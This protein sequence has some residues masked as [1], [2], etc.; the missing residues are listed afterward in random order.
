MTELGEI[1]PWMIGSAIVSALVV[2]GAVV[3]S[4]WVRKSE[5]TGALYGLSSSWTFS[6]SWASNVTVASTALLAVLASTDVV[7]VALGDD[8]AESALA[9]VLVAS[10][11]SAGLVG[12]APLVLKALVTAD[13][14][15]H[16]AGLSIAALLTLTGVGIEIGVASANADR[17]FG[18]DTPYIVI[19][20]LV[21][22]AVAATYGFRSL[23]DLLKRTETVP[24]PP[25]ETLQA[26]GLIAEAILA[27]AGQAALDEVKSLGETREADPPPP[28]RRAAIL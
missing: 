14:Y 23:H 11:I 10:A 16:A 28:R 9:I 13:G 22:A 21:V 1:V 24:D 4:S 12:L 26:A 6:E 20:G 8:Q 25:S 27:A 7:P 3:T 15:F 17:L 19:T 18:G 5:A 2:I